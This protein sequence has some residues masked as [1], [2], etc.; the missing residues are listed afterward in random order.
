[1]GDFVY[2]IALGFWILK[3]TGSTAMMGTLMAVSTVP[4]VIISPFAGVLVDRMNRKWLIVV[5]DLLSGVLILLIAAAA[6]FD[7]LEVWMVFAAGIGLGVF[8]SFLS[9]AVQSTIPDI[10]PSKE[11]IRANSSLSMV[12]N[13]SRIFGSSLGGPLFQI[14]G[15]PL[16]F[17][18][19]GVSYILS[20]ASELFIKI[21][22]HHLK[23]ENDPFFKDMK[24]GISFVWNFKGLR[25]LYFHTLVTMF[26]AVMSYILILPLFERNENLGPAL[27]GAVIA[28][29]A[30]GSLLGYLLISIVKIK[31]EQ[32]ILVMSLTGILYSVSRIFFPF[33][34]SFYVMMPLMFMGGA[35]ISITGTF[36]SSSIQLA[37][38]RDKRGK[39]FGL[40]AILIGGLTPFGMA[41]GGVFAE[42]V[43]LETLISAAGFICLISFSVLY[44]LAPVRKLV[45]FDPEKESV[46]SLF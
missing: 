21:P 32:R 46:E 12:M 20:A 22:S 42:F 18:V 19:N 16:M 25:Y 31:P 33:F 44:F 17:L 30:T 7:F 6:Y 36:F 13:V 38:P 28:S 2:N 34:P 4:R 5:S 29:F 3:A 9:P 23:R 11:L 39:V 10:V 45:N 15:A 14:L 26:F 8:G 24:A 1:M 27:Y 41:L 43:P 40:Q 35:A 37:V